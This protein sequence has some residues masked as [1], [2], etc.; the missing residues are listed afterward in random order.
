VLRN[1]EN[2]DLSPS[3]PPQQLAAAALPAGSIAELV[4]RF[5]SRAAATMPAASQTSGERKAR[6]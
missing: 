3:I 1:P 2:D 6:R 5:A 4:R